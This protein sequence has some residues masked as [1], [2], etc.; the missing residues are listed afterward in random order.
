[1]SSESS[2]HKKVETV[3]LFIWEKKSTND[4]HVNYAKIF[5]TPNY[6]VNK[7]DISG[8]MSQVTPSML[9]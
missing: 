3:Q 8:R 4:A 2:L 9:C 7:Q 6:Y 1:M 5:K